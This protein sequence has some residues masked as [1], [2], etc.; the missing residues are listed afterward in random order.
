VIQ[1]RKGGRVLLTLD[2]LKVQSGLLLEAS[3]G[4]PS[5]RMREF[6]S[7]PRGCHSESPGQV[8]GKKEKIK[9]KKGRK[10]KT[11]PP[12]KAPLKQYRGQRKKSHQEM[13]RRKTHFAA[14]ERGRNS[15][16]AISRGSKGF[17]A[18]H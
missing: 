13:D 5:S 14:K 15:K 11:Y 12:R 7:D 4:A 10:K 9:L 17:Y 8:G 3:G 16:A 6:Q 1:R 2:G 18:A